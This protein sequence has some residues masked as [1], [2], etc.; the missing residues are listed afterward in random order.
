MNISSC[1]N[2]GRRC[3]EEVKDLLLK[4]SPELFPDDI[5]VTSASVCGEDLKLSPLAS[6]KYPFIV[7]CKNQETIRIWQ[8]LK[9]SE[10]HAE[11]TDKVPVLFF[12]RNRSEMYVALKA[13]DFIK[14]FKKE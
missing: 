9:Q 5:L 4:H 1:K 7:E 6:K 2:K 3:A 8:A 12:K 14:H 10:S 13:S 11:G